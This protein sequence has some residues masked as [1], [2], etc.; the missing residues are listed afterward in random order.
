[1]KAQEA[2]KRIKEFGLYHAIVDLPHSALTVEAF[3]MACKALE[4]EQLII[5]SGKHYFVDLIEIRRNV[6]QTCHNLINDKTIAEKLYMTIISS[7]EDEITD[8]T[9]Y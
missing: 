4:R 6:N 3:E 9:L 8:N 2:I 1:M 5:D 7:L